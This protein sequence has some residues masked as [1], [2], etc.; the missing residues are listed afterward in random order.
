MELENKTK[1]KA[2]GNCPYCGNRVSAIVIEENI[3]RRDK[4][5]CPSCHEVIYV[6]RWPGCH[7]YTV[8]GDFYDDELCPKCG[9][10]IFDSTTSLVK[11]AAGIITAEF[12]RKNMKK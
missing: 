1:T 9:K 10:D 4:C 2:M 8:G 3:L 12:I 11:V 5:E 7:N 6:C